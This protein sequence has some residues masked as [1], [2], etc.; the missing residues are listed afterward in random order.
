[1][2]L[3]ASDPGLVRLASNENTDVPSPRVRAALGRVWESANLYATTD[4]LA[5]AI[6]AHHDLPVEG[7]L[8]GAGSTEVIDATLRT[9]VR[10][11]D[12]VV[13]TTPSWPVS[14]AF[15]QALE[16]TIIDVP[17]RIGDE[18]WCFDVDGVLAAIGP[19]T[20]LV[21]VC[22]PNN[23]TGNAMALD[24][25]R[26][27]AA[28]GVPFLVDAA[29]SDFDPECDLTVLVREFENV[30]LTR[31]FAKA[32]ALA[33]LRSGYGLGSAETIDFVDRFMAP[34][35]TISS[36]AVDAALAGLAD[37]EHHDAQV[38][39]VVS[40]RGRVLTAL[41][42]LGLRAWESRANFVSI[43]AAALAGGAEGFAEAVLAYRVVVRPLYDLVR[44][45]IGLPDENDSMLAAVSAALS[46][47]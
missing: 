33:G 5:A 47:S 18:R 26:R 38:A 36:A 29:Y 16:A 17:L 11:G 41:R 13:A 40:E 2:T 39:R 20:K 23:P 14:R 4:T 43:D 30:M 35:S 12:E 8:V 27:I 9:F 28:A 24:D 37:R 1:M 34:G 10:G 25:L 7:V 45:T 15:L 42:S 32:Y 6:A 3:A 46:S 21:L 31:T 22:T 44:I 19:A